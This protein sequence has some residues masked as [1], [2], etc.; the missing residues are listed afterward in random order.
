MVPT[1]FLRL[2]YLNICFGNIYIVAPDNYR[3][4]GMKVLDSLG[5]SISAIVKS[6]AKKKIFNINLM[7]LCILGLI[8]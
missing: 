5:K 4:K 3:V 6:N 1:Q 8:L 2:G 7:F